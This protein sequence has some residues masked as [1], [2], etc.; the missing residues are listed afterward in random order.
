MKFVVAQLLLLVN[1]AAVA[2]S[3]TV[4]T[5]E[6]EMI[7]FGKTNFGDWEEQ[8]IQFKGSL[9][10]YLSGT[11]L[12]GVSGLELQIPVKA[13]KAP[14][15]GMANDTYEAL[16]EKEHPEIT[17]VTKSVLLDNGLAAFDGVL[18]IAGVSRNITITTTYSYIDKTI[19][20]VGD[21]VVLMSDYNIE[22]PTAMLGTLQAD[23]TVNIKF[24]LVFK[25]Y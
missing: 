15:K 1:L 21:Y 9:H 8:V 23:Q 4:N 24:K 18:T 3:Y 7:L 2:Q 6:S 16:K 19:T 12:N 25:D 17:F 20:F 11:R 14:R 22:P 13:L 5:A 10:A